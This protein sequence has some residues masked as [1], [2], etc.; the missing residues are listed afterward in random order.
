MPA[1]VAWRSP[2]HIFSTPTTSTGPSPARTASWPRW[3]AEAPPA[4]PLS[5]LTTCAVPS[6][7]S[8]SHDWPRTHSWSESSPP[9]AFATTISD[10]RSGSTSASARAWWAAA[11]ASSA[12]P[13]VSRPWGVIP[14]P[15]MRTSVT[16]AP[17]LSGGRRLAPV[18]WRA[19]CRAVGRGRRTAARRGWRRGGG[20]GRRRRRTGTGAARRP[21]RRR[22]CGR[23]TRVRCARHEVAPEAVR[24]EAVQRR[25]PCQAAAAGG[26]GPAVDVHEQQDTARVD[27]GRAA[28]GEDGLGAELG[29][30]V[31]QRRGRQE[32][33]DPAGASPRR[34]AEG[35][36]ARPADPHRDGGGRG[37]LLVA[38]VRRSPQALELVE[39]RIDLPPAAGE[40]DA[41][42][43]ELALV[44]AGA[45]AE[46]E[47]AAGQQLQRCRGLGHHGRAPEGQLQD[48]G[49][50]RTPGRGG[51]GGRQ[52]GE[53][54]DHRAVPEQVVAR[55]QGVDPGGLGVSDGGAQEAGVERAGLGE[56]GQHQPDSR[57]P[58]RAS[59]SGR[60]TRDASPSHRSRC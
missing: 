1:S 18:R 29:V 50:E 10:R 22:R 44:D 6:P 48:G 53:R 35:R 16:G 19:R 24:G 32:H 46:D 58:R 23:R 59:Q 17:S 28:A 12:G 20:P 52:C 30:A 26:L 49:A 60:T 38:V 8:N 3:M 34:P 15:A 4:Q 39:G 33:G 40:V 54:L 41:G 27:V 25:H 37:Q 45:D 51:R 7:D 2:V 47:A 11:R 43:R 31:A 56:R 14:T 36:V 13:W 55:P 57:V 5:T 21:P 42:R 9:R